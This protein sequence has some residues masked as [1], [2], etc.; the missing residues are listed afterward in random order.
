MRVGDG[1]PGPAGLGRARARARREGPGGAPR[2]RRAG[3]KAVSVRSSSAWVGVL[4]PEAADRVSQ[5]DCVRGCAW[6][7]RPGHGSRGG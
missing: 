3:V 6:T 2:P 5:R 7:G 4:G 1:G